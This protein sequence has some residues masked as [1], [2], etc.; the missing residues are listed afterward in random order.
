MLILVIGFSMIG[1]LKVLA[2]FSLAANVIS[3]GG[4]AQSKIIEE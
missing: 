4:K 2:P 1:S 3:I